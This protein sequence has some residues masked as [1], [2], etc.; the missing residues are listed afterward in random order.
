[1][2]E[3]LK[4]KRKIVQEAEKLDDALDFATELILAQVCLFLTGMQSF[5]SGLTSSLLTGSGGA[6]CRQCPAVR[7]GDGDCGS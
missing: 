6:F 1:M 3:L 7:A 2:E 5:D 4:V